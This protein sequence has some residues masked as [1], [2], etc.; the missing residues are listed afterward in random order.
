VPYNHGYHFFLSSQPN[1]VFAAPCAAN[2][3]KRQLIAPVA[4]QALVIDGIVDPGLQL[5]LVTKNEKC[6]AVG[7]VALASAIDDLV[8]RARAF[9]SGPFRHQQPL[10]QRLV[11]EGQA[12]KILMISC[13]DSRVDPSVI[14]D[15]D[16]G[17]IFMVR[18]VASLVPPCTP[19]QRRHG[20]SAALEFGILKLGVEH[21]VVL[22]HGHC[23]GIEA[24]LHSADE[25]GA[26]SDFI[27]PWL[28][29]VNDVRDKVV[30]E[31]GEASYADK[32]RALEYATVRQSVRNL[33][34]F[35]WI[36]ERVVEGRLSLQGWHYDIAEGALYA[37]GEHSEPIQI[38]G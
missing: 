19:D 25:D 26:D 6:N 17:E 33:R 18:N 8:V 24:L 30:R 34:T 32:A 16:P 27:G 5:L 23:G 35:P 21:V 28:S 11:N 29:C 14:F 22:G 38:S 15:A 12:P 20:T 31:M 9:H 4:L 7:G 3:T 37:V 13:S 1:H 10:Y 36:D 2:H